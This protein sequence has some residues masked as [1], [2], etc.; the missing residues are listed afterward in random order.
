[1]YIYLALPQDSVHKH[2][3]KFTSSLIHKILRIKDKPEGLLL[4]PI[5]YILNSLTYPSLFPAENCFS[6]FMDIALAKDKL[7][8]MTLNQFIFPTVDIQMTNKDDS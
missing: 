4:I 1:M 8:S 5:I 7:I 2:D 6:S 3:A